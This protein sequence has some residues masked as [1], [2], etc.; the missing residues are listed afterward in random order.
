MH[1]RLRSNA[2]V[3]QPRAPLRLLLRR[4]LLQF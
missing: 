4:L 2:Q 1:Q 3:L